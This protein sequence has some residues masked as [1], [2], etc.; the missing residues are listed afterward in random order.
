[1]TVRNAKFQGPAQT[2]LGHQSVQGGPGMGAL[3]GS[4]RLLFPE[5]PAGDDRAGAF[6][7]CLNSGWK[8]LGQVAVTA[9]ANCV[10]GLFQGLFPLQLLISWVSGLETL[11]LS[12]EV[13]GLSLLKTRPVPRRVYKCVCV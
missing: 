7:V 2:Y 6:Q 10:A 8:W 11:L 12:V 5:H 9:E 4:Y 13:P 1:M 3:P